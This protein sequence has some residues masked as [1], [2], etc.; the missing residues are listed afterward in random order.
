MRNLKWVNPDPSSYC[1]ATN[2]EPNFTTIFKIP[3]ESN[4]SH[5]KLKLKSNS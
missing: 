3:K 2:H 4:G 5:K 1:N